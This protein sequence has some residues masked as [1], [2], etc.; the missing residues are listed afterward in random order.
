M[1]FKF[2]FGLFLTLSAR[3]KLKSSIFQMPVMAA[4]KTIVSFSRRSEKM[5]FPKKLRCNMIFLVLLGKIM[6]LF[7]ENM[8]LTL[9]RK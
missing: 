2:F 7:H 3:E 1:V 9:D 4:R 5:V 6:F 8:I